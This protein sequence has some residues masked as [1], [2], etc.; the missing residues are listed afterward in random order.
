M[1]VALISPPLPSQRHPA[2]DASLIFPIDQSSSST[3]FPLA[4][5]SLYILIYYVLIYLFSCARRIDIAPI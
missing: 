2:L 3:E 1:G 4:F 5:I